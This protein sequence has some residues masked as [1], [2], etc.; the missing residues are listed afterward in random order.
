VVSQFEPGTNDSKEN[1]LIRNELIAMLAHKIVIVQASKE[2]GAL[3]ILP[4]VN[5]KLPFS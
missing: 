3:Y 4:I 2:R 5:C 1:F